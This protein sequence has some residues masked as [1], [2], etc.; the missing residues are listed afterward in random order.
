VT[1]A[2]LAREL[3]LHDSSVIRTEQRAHVQPPT[4]LRYL[5]ALEICVARKREEREQL[6]RRLAQVSRELTGKAR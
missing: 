2:E 6:A 3:M 1:I 4:V 5:E